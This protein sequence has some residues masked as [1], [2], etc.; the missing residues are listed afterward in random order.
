M[1]DL[2]RSS[3]KGRV[4]EG[5]ARAGKTWGV[6]QWICIYCQQNKNKG[7][8]IT[9]TRDRLT[10]LKATLFKDF[11]EIL[12]G[13]NWWSEN[14]WNKSEMTY[15]LYGNEI[16]FIGTDEPGKLHGRKQDIFWCNEAIGT[17][18][19]AFTLSR[20]SFDQLEMRTDVGWFLDYN[21]KTTSHWIYDSVLTRPDVEFF[22]CT[23]KD[24]PFLPQ[25]IRTKILSYEPTPENIAI[26]TA[27]RTKWK[28]YGLGERAQHEG[29]IFTNIHWVTEIPQ[30]AK[31]IAYG[32]DFGFTNDVSALMKVC[33]LNGELWVEEIIYETGLT[34]QDLSR[35]FQKAG[36]KPT[37]ELIADSAEQKS[38]AELKAM[39]WNI[40]GVVKGKDSIQFGIDVLKKYRINVHER[41][42]GFKLE[43]ENYVWKEDTQTGKTLNVPVDDFNHGWDAVRYVALMKLASNRMMTV[44]KTH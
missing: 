26:G 9:I 3:A 30:G 8:R 13:L 2:T 34:N 21:P 38:I 10:W 29:L 28:I 25:S 42:T 4:L 6:I 23:Q 40:S 27:D 18:G 36:I 41:S 1:R 19:S 37:D 44:A 24:N 31:L 43:T 35:R 32:L 33:L 12:E 22:H 14:D 5:G 17:P 7:K 15:S 20:E 39:G 16:S 11:R